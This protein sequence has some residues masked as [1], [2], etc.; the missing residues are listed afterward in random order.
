M[1]QEEI[2]VK[3]K[4]QYYDVNKKANNANVNSNAKSNS[5]GTNSGS[6]SSNNNNKR[7][8]KQLRTCLNNKQM[9]AKCVAIV[10]KL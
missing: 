10:W 2:Q 6:S 5:I 4:C 1:N 3:H 9:K 7:Y 8:N